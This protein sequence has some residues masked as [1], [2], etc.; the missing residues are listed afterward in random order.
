MKK[1]I[2]N[3]FITL[4]LLF[5]FQIYGIN[6]NTTIF[7]ISAILFLIIIMIIIIFYYNKLSPKILI[8]ILVFIAV[9]SL[10][11]FFNNIPF[12]RF[13]SSI[14]WIC[15]YI[16]IFASRDSEIFNYK[17]LMKPLLITIN[18]DVLI[19]FYQ[20]F[21]EKI[22][23][24][25]GIFSEPTTAGLVFLS[26]SGAFIFC[27]PFVKNNYVKFLIINY[28]TILV[29]LSSLI[30]TTH[31]ISFLISMAIAY[32]LYTKFKISNLLILLSIVLLSVIIM[33]NSDHIMSRLDINS[34]ELNY[35]QLA[36]LSGFQQMMESIKNSPL[37]GQGMGGTGYFNYESMYKDILD[38]TGSGDLG[39]MDAYSGLF[40]IVIECGLFFSAFIIYA[41]FLRIREF[42]KFVSNARLNIYKTGYE[43]AFLFIFGQTMLLGVLLKESVWSRS[44]NVLAIILFFG[45]SLQY[46]KFNTKNS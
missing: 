35:S 25:S 2:K 14:T 5:P 26:A 45:I 4:V 31:F 1:I 42:R 44:T 12:Y 24:P 13:I 41:I 43:T 30:L 9:Q 28:I 17:Y 3:L 11:L 7:D 32:L 8:F 10:I 27:L 6:V 36:W 18:I 15:S 39:L 19:T 21:I 38:S 33:F 16:I 34:G 29:Y 40:R 20:Y 22:E 46:K 23:R 37:F